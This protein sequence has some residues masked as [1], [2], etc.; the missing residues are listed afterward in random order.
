M[1]A[2]IAERVWNAYTAYETLGNWVSAEAFFGEDN[3]LVVVVL[4][5]NMLANSSKTCLSLS[6]L[7]WQRAQDPLERSPAQR[8]PYRPAENMLGNC[9]DCV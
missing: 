4:D 3:P 9:S 1:L 8:K 2:P 5:R 6:N 7:P